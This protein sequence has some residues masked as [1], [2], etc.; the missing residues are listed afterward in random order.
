MTKTQFMRGGVLAASLALGAAPAL[1]EETDRW[2]LTGDGLGPIT[3]DAIVRV[4]QLR[5][6][7]PELRIVS[8]VFDAEGVSYARIVAYE[9]EE[10]VIEMELIDGRF[11]DIRIFTPRASDAYG[12]SVGLTFA[13]IPVSGPSACFDFEAGQPYAACPSGP[14]EKIQYLF[15]GP[16]SA[17]DASSEVIGIRLW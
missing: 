15:D 12:V 2:L 8:E 7:Y 10:R 9:E 11:R 14:A 4:D 6:T 17:I 1:A 16:A 3:R 5:E 13:D